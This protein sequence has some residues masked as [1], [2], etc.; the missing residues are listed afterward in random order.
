MPHNIFSCFFPLLLLAGIVLSLVFAYRGLFGSGIQVDKN[1]RLVGRSAR[2]AGAAC[3]LAA[4]G[5]AAF[6]AWLVITAA[7]NR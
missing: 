4:L 3:L 1:A 5:M 2:I 7:S 6:V